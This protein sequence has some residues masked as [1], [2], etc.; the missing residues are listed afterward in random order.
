MPSLLSGTRT[1]A[2]S[3][4]S[5]EGISEFTVLCMISDSILFVDLFRLTDLS[6]C[7]EALGR[8]VM[9]SSRLL[10]QVQSLSDHCLR[11]KSSPLD[12]EACVSPLPFH[13]FCSL[14]AAILEETEAKAVWWVAPSLPRQLDRV[15]PARCKFR[16]M[17]MT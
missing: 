4:A 17:K 2:A 8:C 7:M 3:P 13:I 15:E 5:H 11:S 1:Q 6:L 16:K 14:F 9:Q 10:L 12:A